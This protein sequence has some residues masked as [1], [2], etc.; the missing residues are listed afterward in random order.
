MKKSL[1]RL[2][3]SSLLV[4]AVFLSLAGR[5]SCAGLPFPNS[6]FEEGAA[7][8]TIPAA[9]KGMSRVA[10]E[11]AR[12]GKLGLL[13]VDADTKAG[14]SARSDFLPAKAGETYRLDFHARVVEGGGIA[15]YLQFYD[16]GRKLIRPD[17]S[18]GDRELLRVIPPGAKDWAALTLAGTAPAG[19][20]FAAVWVHSFSGNRVTA[21]FDDFSVSAAPVSAASEFP[22]DAGATRPSAT[23][24][25]VAP[26]P[27]FPKPDP[28]KVFAGFKIIQ[29][30]GSAYRTPREDWEGAR[31][32]VATDPAWKKWTDEQR[33]AADAWMARNRDR[34]G[35]E[36]GWNHDFISPASGAWLVWTE[37]V[38][39]EETGVILSHS[40]EKVAVSGNENPKI[41]RAWVGAFRKRHALEMGKIASVY[42]FT[43]DKRYAEWVCAQLDF[44]ADNYNSWGKGVAQ[45]KNSHLG[46]QSLDD[47][48]IVSRLVEAARPVFDYAG[49]VR[50]QAW[51]DKLFR[52][53]AELLGRTYGFIHNIATWQRAAQ[54]QIALLY[55]DEGLLDKAM[56]G[57]FGLRAQIDRGVTG[58]YFWFEQSMGYNDFIVMATAP[59]FTFAGLIGRQDRIAREA[60]IVQNLMIAPLYIRF[61]DGTIPN[62][63]DNGGRPRVPSGWFA[64]AYRIWPTPLGLR[65][66]AK[67]DERSWSALVDPPEQIAGFERV[68]D[69]LP[70]VTSRNM[71][72]TR[73]ALLRKGPWQVF[74]HYGQLLE[75]HRQSEALN[76]SASWNGT[77]ISHDPGNVGYGAQSTQWYYRRGLNHN[78]PLIDGEG[79]RTWDPGKLVRFDPEAG[80]VEA[81][82]SRYWLAGNT[83]MPP[84]GW[85]NAPESLRSGTGV[86]ADRRLHIDGE[87][88]VEETGVALTDPS[89]TA[90]LGLSLHLQGKMRP[91]QAESETVFR[92]VSAAEF[93][94]G[95]T[96]TFTYWQDVQV[97]SC[98]DRASV[99]VEFADGVVMRVEFAVTGGGAFTLYQGSSPDLPPPARRAGFYL[100]LDEPRAAARFMTVIRPVGKT[101]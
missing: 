19:T 94:K 35:W 36:A 56:G 15:V 54:A 1:R 78:V 16:A 48:V 69:A 9:D 82:Q 65:H 100:E 49:P 93:A 63:A 24:G 30:D 55:G 41:F 81:G 97:A 59:L 79:Q 33:A 53:E 45:R 92:P 37:D 75:S 18:S 64:R 90:R 47:A 87:A 32:R 73:F 25:A 80:V 5:A 58:D 3:S 10:P 57:P 42:Q 20:A 44:Y 17:S 13:V 52:P 11:A 61:P 89:V 23:S 99:D 46:Y 76:W 98:R 62:P 67:S 60:T 96:K 70:E 39:G 101:G 95:R 22:T 14:S 7:R 77:D 28:E 91:S 34:A 50:R 31:R 68:S 51:F 6:G 26:V 8:W 66:A 74:F 29:P 12:T 2:S 40:G 85:E 27:V 84:W 4:L 38:P 83:R 21:H 72:S 43:G 71:E 86:K 88:L